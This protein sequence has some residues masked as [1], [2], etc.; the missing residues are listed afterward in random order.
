MLATYGADFYAGEPA[1]T[2]NQFGQGRAYYLATA[3][4]ADALAGFLGKLCAD[5]GITPPVVG[6]PAGLEV[7]PRVS[8]DGETLLYVLNHNPYPIAVL[9]PEGGHMDLLT[10]RALSGEIEL[11]AHGVL[12]LAPGTV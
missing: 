2:V 6:A 4:D 7:V 3:L 5:K 8:P 12:I 1:V 9:L 11:E 10:G